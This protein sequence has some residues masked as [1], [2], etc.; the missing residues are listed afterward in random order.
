MS[1]EDVTR[2]RAFCKKAEELCGVGHLLRSAEYYGRA[3]EAARA[4]GPDNLVAVGAQRFQAHVLLN[5]LTAVDDDTADAR[6][7]SAYRANIVALLSTVVAALERRRLAGTLLEG[8][9][10]ATEEAW[11]AAEWIVADGWSATATAT[12]AKL[13]G[14]T[15]FIRTADLISGLFVN[16]F[17]FAGECSASQ[18]QSFAQHVVHCTD[19]MQQPRSYNTTAIVSETSFVKEFPI[20][21]ADDSSG[22]THVQRRG[23]DPRLAQLLKGAWQ[24][25]QRSGVLEARGVFDEHRRLCQSTHADQHSA[26]VRDAM[27]APGLRSC[28]LAGCGAKEAH[29]QHFKSC[30][31]YRTVVYCC[32]EHQVEGWPAHKK[33]CKAA[34]KAAGGG[35]GAGPG[36]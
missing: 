24:R 14:Y 10:T 23:L 28:A 18:F 5:Y 26:A 16:A 2:A 17:F 1:S 32:R 33:A 4:L 3:A 31:A 22:V 20:I 15:T 30:A 7:I 13:F 8:K 35:G 21:L 34:S 12:W 9:C 6:V 19:L 27:S 11:Y 36:A 25:L 29:P